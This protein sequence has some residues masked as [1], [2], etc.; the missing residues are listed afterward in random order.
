M[1]NLLAITPLLL[2]SIAVS[3]Q[4]NSVNDIVLASPTLGN[5]P[6]GVSAQHA[7]QGE[8]VQVRST[9]ERQR[10][11]FN[12]NLSAFDGRLIRQAKVTLRG[13]AGANVLPASSN[14]RSADV[15]ESFT[16][17]PGSMPKPTF[18]SVVY[19][20]R[21]TGVR[22]IDVDEVTYA[23]GKQWHQTDN[24]VCRVAPNG[25]LLVNSTVK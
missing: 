7:P 12:I 13:I 24:S 14:P 3:A 15:S 23:S 25:L 9:G 18:Q 22:W 17:T 5:C 4:T 11:G 20:E 16:I 6:V 10:L 19:A 21:L 1:R 2:F 8:I